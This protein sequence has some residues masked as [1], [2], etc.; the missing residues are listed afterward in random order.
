MPRP[1]SV[2]DASTGGCNGRAG[3]G[4]SYGTS[5]GAA[6]TREGL[7]RRFG[8]QGTPRGVLHASP[9]SEPRSNAGQQGT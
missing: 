1:R 9:M 6:V 5:W 7:R 4:M 2:H 8:Y 3:R